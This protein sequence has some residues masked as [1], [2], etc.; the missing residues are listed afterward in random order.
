MATEAIIQSGPT[1]PFSPKTSHT[2]FLAADTLQTI[3]VNSESQRTQANEE[4]GQSSGNSSTALFLVAKVLANLSQETIART[5]LSVNS[6]RLLT[7]SEPTPPASA[8]TTPA[9]AKPDSLPL[10]PDPIPTTVSEDG[11]QQEAP[12]YTP[13]PLIPQNETATE[14]TETLNGSGQAPKTPQSASPNLVSFMNIESLLNA[15]SNTPNSSLNCS[16]T[17]DDSSG[18]TSSVSSFTPSTVQPQNYE[19]SPQEVPH[20][21]L[22]SR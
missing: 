22:R 20:T 2:A 1:P 21:P 3:N 9:S 16:T 12:N 14:E 5:C 13:P 15:A 18:A 6:E 7:P 11:Q 4:G 8:N 17:S 19:G 10:P